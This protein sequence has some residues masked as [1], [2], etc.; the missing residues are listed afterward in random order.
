MRCGSAP[1]ST[2]RATR[3]A[4]VSVLPEP[5]PA[6]TS[7]GPCADSPPETEP[8]GAALAVVQARQE[9]VA[10]RLAARKQRQRSSQVERAGARSGRQSVRNCKSIQPA[11]AN[12]A[13]AI[14]P[15]AASLPPPSLPK[16]LHDLG[17]KTWTD[18]ARPLPH[19]GTDRSRLARH[20]PMASA[21]ASPPLA[22]A[23]RRRERGSR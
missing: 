23:G 12:P 5:A 7:S 11:S 10:E 13:R 22:H 4:S 18:R 14:D 6:M 21:L 9:A 3:A 19:D 8:G 1:A 17:D 20:S 15:G 2:R 16:T